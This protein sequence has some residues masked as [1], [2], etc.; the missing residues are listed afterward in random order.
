MLSLTSSA[1]HLAYP[2]KVVICPDTMVIHSF[3]KLAFVPLPIP[4]ATTK[5][6]EWV[7]V[8]SS[9]DIRSSTSPALKINGLY[10]AILRET[11]RL[12]GDF[13]SVIG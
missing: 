10:N 1:L 9:L 12:S 8:S 5:E 3:Y 2:P 11:F 7:S 4:G 6:T 13:L